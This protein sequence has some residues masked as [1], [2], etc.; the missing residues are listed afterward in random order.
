MNDLTVLFEV[1]SQGGEEQ[2]PP[3]VENQNRD[4]I[5]P[6]EE[7][8]P[9]PVK[10][11]PRK[12]L[13][14]VPPVQQKQTHTR[15]RAHGSAPK[16]S[17]NHQQCALD[18]IA[19]SVKHEEEEK[20]GIKDAKEELAEEHVV[21]LP[22]K[23]LPIPPKRELPKDL[24][25][26][27]STYYSVDESGRMHLDVGEGDYEMCGIWRSCDETV[28][29]T[30]CP[31]CPAG[32]LVLKAEWLAAGARACAAN[33]CL[34]GRV[35]NVMSAL[36]GLK[37]LRTELDFDPRTA[38]ELEI[39]AC[40][41]VAMSQSRCRA[42]D[43]LF[44][45]ECRRP[46]MYYTDAVDGD[47]QEV[48]KHFKFSDDWANFAASWKRGVVMAPY[49]LSD[50]DI[51]IP[52][53]SDRDTLY[54]G[55]RK[56]LYPE[57]RYEDASRKRWAKACE[58][59]QAAVKSRAESWW[60][61]ELTKASFKDRSLEDAAWESFTAGH[62]KAQR[63]LLEKGRD[64]VH[65]DPTEA[66]RYYLSRPYKCFV[67]KEVYADGTKPPRFIMCLDEELRGIQFGFMWLVLLLIEQGT[68]FCNVKGKTSQE[69]TETVRLKFAG[70]DRV[71]E[72]DFTSCESNITPEVKAICENSLYKVLM[73]VVGYGDPYHNFV[74]QALGRKYVKLI[75]P[76]FT[77]DMF[78]HIRMSGDLWTSLGNLY[79][80][81]CTCFSCAYSLAEYTEK[82]ALEFIDTSL[83][84]GDDGLFSMREYSIQDM[85]SHATKAGFL[86]KFDVGN[87][88]ELSFCGNHYVHVDGDLVKY[89]DPIKTAASLC[90][91]F[92]PDKDTPK[93]LPQL[94][95]AK[96]ISCLLGPW[97]PG[98]SVFACCIERLTRNVRINN[99]Y[100]ENTG[101][102][103]K[104]SEYKIEGCLP[105]VCR[106]ESERD[107]AEGVAICDKAA[108]GIRRRKDVLR[109]FYTL[110][111]THM[112]SYETDHV[113][114]SYVQE[115]QKSWIKP[116]TTSHVHVHKTATY[117]L[118]RAATYNPFYLLQSIVRCAQH[119]GLVCV[120][121]GLLLTALQL[122]RGFSCAFAALVLAA[123]Q[124]QS[125]SV[126]QFH[127]KMDICAPTESAPELY[128]MSLMFYAVAFCSVVVWLSLSA[129]R[130]VRMYDPKWHILFARM[131][132]FDRTWVSTVTHSCWIIP[133]LWTLSLVAAEL[134]V[135]QF[136]GAELAFIFYTSF[137]AGIINVIYAVN[138]VLLKR[139]R[140][141]K[142]YWSR[143]SMCDDLSLKEPF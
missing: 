68:H 24:V 74:D 31:A 105:P 44:H 64:M 125:A 133:T 9:E 42:A 110:R 99:Q 1:H 27:F 109:M 113:C 103:R 12:K 82:N 83:F 126:L 18:Q 32:F 14:I 19:E 22:P 41:I 57:I 132:R 79:F 87:W 59:M 94:Q 84:E 106:I 121:A 10:T 140:F 130:W 38:L 142:A 138:R 46:V 120:C 111:D 93:N 107:W 67:K 96:A 136:Q 102:L 70:N 104:Y 73:D 122:I 23:P 117:D 128:R 69:I 118:Y 115:F 139:F 52:D 143:K 114:G 11:A 100:L 34:D 36:S 49:T 66:L 45:F 88:D 137:W 81:L 3:P 101:R 77:A 75:G 72:T 54:R 7:K 39:V 90:V 40:V 53:A 16:V 51:N 56:R 65:Q 20:Q 131:L 78:H 33:Y 21:L 127:S 25:L 63:E 29:F 86:L 8:V 98:A 95:R 141:S 76:V 91:V 97:V 60:K 108:G 55:L 4:V 37:G 134:G 135:E 129:I 71:V 26:E 5:T 85:E 89:R 80:N 119:L 61:D 30:H 50:V 13:R 62:T 6:V 2:V 116:I 123:L 92:S 43:F 58:A 28:R 15:E 48:N 112:A 47:R 17:K 124:F 35:S